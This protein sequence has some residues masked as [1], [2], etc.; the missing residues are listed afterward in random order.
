M[1]ILGTSGEMKM[2]EAVASE[3]VQPV[4]PISRNFWMVVLNSSIST[5]GTGSFG[6][7]IIWITLALTG[8]T[9][10]AGL[11]DGMGAAPLFLSF[12]L[13]AYIDSLASKKNIAI[14]VSVVR[15]ASIFAL[16][17]AL[18]S[19]STFVMIAAIYFVAFSIGLNSDILNS[20]GASWTKQ[21]LGETQYKKGTSLMQSASA[22]SQS[23]S[24][25]LAGVLILFGFHFAVYGFAAI[26]G[27][28]VVPLL[29]LRNDR[30]EVM[31][32]KS[33]L[34]SSIAEGLSYIASSPALIAIIILSLMANLAFG[35]IGILA[36][37]LVQDELA[38][39]AIYFTVF[40]VILTLGVFFG[41]ALGSKVKGKV[42]PVTIVTLLAVGGLYAFFGLT[43]DIYFD[44]PVSFAIGTL[45]GIVNVVSMTALVKMVDQ[46]KMARVV[47]AIKTFAVSVTFISGTIGGVLIALISLS[48]S[49]YLIGG[50]IVVSALLPFFF[51]EF[52]D[53]PI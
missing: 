38:L 43:K 33:E 53:L 17:L 51:R 46:D 4:E 37:F 39:P 52:Y 22:L 25:I 41:S 12:A 23:F 5:L 1:A 11:A 6:L 47:G 30:L 26:F 49:F 29:F 44:F 3:T 32:E 7:A 19:S 10:I 18:A 8:S 42:G 20:A 36:A 15:V 13:G 9:V 27:L 28:A 2:E 50:V 24:F 34:H 48:W 45:I 40:F 35:T 14:I 21:F 31:P 16:L